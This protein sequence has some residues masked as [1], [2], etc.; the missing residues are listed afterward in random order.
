[1]CAALAGSTRAHAETDDDADSDTDEKRPAR[2]SDAPLP[3]C[4][5]MTIRDQLGAELKPRGVQKRDFAKNK[6]INLVAHGGIYGGD[7]TSS[8]WI[9]GGSLG[10]FLTE[11]FGIQAQFD[12]TPLTLDLDSPLT[13]FFGDNR[14][15]PGMAYLGL[16]NMM[17]SPMHAKLKMGGGIVHADVMFFAGAGRMFH[18]AVQ[19]LAFDAGMAL[20]MFVTKAMTIRIDIRDVAAVQEIAAET[21]FTNNIVA[22][23]GLAIWI[24]VGL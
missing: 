8:N 21:R 1:M 23:I 4:L 11:D 20:D 6:K 10:F 24:P 13:K 16:V 5:D 17:W 2:P 15:D 3:S 18:D 22:T 14:F 7:L 9:A 12:L 19:G